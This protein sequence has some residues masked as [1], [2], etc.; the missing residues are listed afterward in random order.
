MEGLNGA[1]QYIEMLTDDAAE[2]EQAATW[3]DAID[4]PDRAERFR[5]LAQ[6]RRQLLI[7]IKHTLDSNSGLASGI[8]LVPPI[9]AND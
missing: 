8:H 6:D 4:E 3:A 5:E 1:S 2:W 7:V 9:L